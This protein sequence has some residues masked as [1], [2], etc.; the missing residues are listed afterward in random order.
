M[1]GVSA[2]LHFL[3]DGAA[4]VLSKSASA[5]V[6]EIIVFCIAIAVGAMGFMLTKKLKPE[7][8]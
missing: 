3:V 5:M 2:V 8:E 7:Q 6:V 1:V 4:V